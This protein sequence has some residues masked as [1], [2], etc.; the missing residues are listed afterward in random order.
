MERCRVP[1][2]DGVG[3]TS[4]RDEERSRNV[5]GPVLGGGECTTEGPWGA[6]LR[7]K[8]CSEMADGGWWWCRGAGDGNAGGEVRRRGGEV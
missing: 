4:E 1:A 6:G 2:R 5:D 7:K 3:A 8:C